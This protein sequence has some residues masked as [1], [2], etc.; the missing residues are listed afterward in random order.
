MEEELQ[1]LV[2]QE[3]QAAPPQP[4][5]GAVS[6][7]RDV[8]ISVILAIIMIVF[9]YQP[10]KVEGTSM[11][12]GLTDQERIFINKYTYKLGSGKIERLD[13]VVFYYPY[14]VTQSYIKRIIGLPGD[15]IEIDE[16]TVYVNGRKIDEPYVPAEYRDRRS[17]Q[18]ETVPA[19]MYFVLG[20][21]RSSSNDSRIW[22]FVPRKQIYGKAVFIYWPPNKIGRV[23]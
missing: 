7:L 19:D 3:A 22:G 6:M 2:S 16:G 17:L 23:H 5:F 10:V 20:D 15:T 12:P 21:H 4:G 13:P 11:M 8:A 1:P 18:R 9:V 14:D